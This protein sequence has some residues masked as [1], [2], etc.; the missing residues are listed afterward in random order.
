MKFHQK[1]LT[2]KQKKKPMSN[3]HN[4]LLDVG[5]EFYVALIKVDENRTWERAKL[6]LRVLKIE[7]QNDCCSVSIQET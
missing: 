4:H 6:Q 1:N 5:V 7:W 3:D 2:F